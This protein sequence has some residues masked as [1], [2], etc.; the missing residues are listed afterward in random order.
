[1][2]I[3]KIND[4]KNIDGVKLI[5]MDTFVDHRGEIATIYSKSKMFPEFVEDK[6]TISN[7][8]VL[9]GLH[10]DLY[11]S[12]IIS[13]LFGK[14]E[15][16]VVDARK[17]SITFG[18]SEKFVLS[19]EKLQTVYVPKGCLNGHLCLSNKCIFW[20]K[21]S[22]KYDGPSK[23]FTIKWDDEDLNLDWSIKNPILSDRDL[24]GNYFSLLATE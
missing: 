11:T 20:Y 21:W 3:E 9:R 4:S 1:M 10:G 22:Q 17:N 18:N 7:K 2:F 14:I 5:T 24:N 23:R 15:L 13:C 19:G 12:K 16:F 8:N 6:I